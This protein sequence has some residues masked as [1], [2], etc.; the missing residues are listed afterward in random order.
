MDN[1]SGMV[2]ED[3]GLDIMREFR[4]GGSG[5]C[6]GYSWRRRWMGIVRG[7][8]GKEE[9]VGIVRNRGSREGVW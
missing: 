2:G 3:K 4:G 8:V 1:V 9:G 5:Y 6:K 7:M